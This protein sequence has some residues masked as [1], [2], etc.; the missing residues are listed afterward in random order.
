MHPRGARHARPT[1]R[2]HPA[3]SRTRVIILGAG[4]RDFHNF[5]EFFRRRPDYQVVAF[6]STQIPDLEGRS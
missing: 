2:S 3:A 4:G 1:T 6:T 5:N